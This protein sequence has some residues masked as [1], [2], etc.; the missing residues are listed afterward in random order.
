MRMPPWAHY[1]GGVP[2]VQLVG[3]PGTDPDSPTGLETPQD[4]PGGA[5]MSCYGEGRL[6]RPTKAVAK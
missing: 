5:I 4:P 1:F 6:E 3:E 2:G